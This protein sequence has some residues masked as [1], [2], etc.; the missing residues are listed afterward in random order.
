M[1]ISAFPEIVITYRIGRVTLQLSA[2]CS[3]SQK[4]IWSGLHPWVFVL[5]LLRSFRPR[6]QRHYQKIKRGEGEG[7]SDIYSFSSLPAKSPQASCVPLLEK[8]TMPAGGPHH[9]LSGTLSL[10]FLLA[11]LG[12][13]MT[14]T[15]LLVFMNSAHIFENRTIARLFYCPSLSKLSFHVG[16]LEDLS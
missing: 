10:P 7:D 4:V 15:S 12:L 11:Y 8:A 3:E 2:P 5:W 16:P 14:Y 9:F 1:Q 6:V 13:R